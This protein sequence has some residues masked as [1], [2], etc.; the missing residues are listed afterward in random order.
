MSATENDNWT[1]EETRN[2]YQWL[3]EK[4]SKY[5]ISLRC[6]CSSEALVSIWK[7]EFEGYN[8][9]N[10]ELVDFD[11]VHDALSQSHE[12][13]GD[14]FRECA[15]DFDLWQEHIDPNHRIS[16]GEFE[17]FPV[18]FKRHII[19]F[20]M[21]DIDWYSVFDGTLYPNIIET[22]YNYNEWENGWD[23]MGLVSEN[24]FNIL[25]METK[26]KQ[27]CNYEPRKYKRKT[28]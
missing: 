13:Q 16:R 5:N 19:E 17:S 18:R 15:T 6:G 10:T 8:D 23:T 22:A 4:L 11:E 3:T 27:M 25:S 20:L 1:N 12:R 26:L 28:K 21:E 7:E 9:I 24:Q 14:L 2:C